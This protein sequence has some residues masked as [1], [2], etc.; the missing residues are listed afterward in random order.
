MTKSQFKSLVAISWLLILAAIYAGIVAESQLPSVLNNYLEAELEKDFTISEIVIFAFALAAMV[1]NIGLFFF[2]RWARPVFATSVTI[3][4]AG[5][6][7]FGPT[8]QTALET[9]VY[10]VSL[11]IDGALIALIYFSELKSEFNAS[12]T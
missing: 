5:M 11:L 7:F 8:V 2:A 10:E 6:V 3:T 9:S 1:S 12:H 4:T